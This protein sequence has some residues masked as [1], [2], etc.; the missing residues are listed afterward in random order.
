[1]KSYIHA[2]AT[3]NCYVAWKCVQ[4]GSLCAQPTSYTAEADVRYGFFQKQRA[5]ETATRSA[6]E[7]LSQGMLQVMYD[8]NQRHM[9]R[10]LKVNGKCPHCR[11]AQPWRRPYTLNRIL[12]ILAV[13]TS[14]AAPYLVSRGASVEVTDSFFSFLLRLVFL[15]L[16]A[17]LLCIGADIL[18][19]YWA[20]GKLS[21]LKDPLV[22][23]ILVHRGVPEGVAE[24]D[25]RLTAVVRC[26][27]QQRQP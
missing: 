16:L 24:D 25:P 13:L 5:I 4:C 12:L 3:T 18:F 11:T 27:L 19:E 7:D 17:H 22:Y 8:V 1:M 21:K 2:T 23:P 9:F 10:R 6:R 20:E 26:I 14:I 15:C